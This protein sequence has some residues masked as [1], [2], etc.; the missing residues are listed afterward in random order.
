MWCLVVHCRT[1][2]A[3]LV[4]LLVVPCGTLWN[5]YGGACGTLVHFVVH[6]GTLG[7]LA[8]P[9]R[10]FLWYVSAPRVPLWRFLYHLVAPLWC[11][12]GGACG[13]LW[14]RVVPCVIVAGAPL[15]RYLVMPCVA[16][17]G[18]LAIPRRTVVVPGACGTLWYCCSG[19]CGTA[20]VPC[21]N[22]WHLCGSP[23]G[24]MLV[25]ACGALC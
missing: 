25:P 16:V 19:A 10:W 7:H 22:F 9:S 6:C 13:T 4:E 1:M 8:V 18:L 21:G 12:C 2:V 3:V 11:R 17:A 20:V 5:R 14:S 15:Q 24:T 23:W